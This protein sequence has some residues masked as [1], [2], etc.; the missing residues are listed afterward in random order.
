M[1]V[2]YTGHG[3]GDKYGRPC[4]TVGNWD[5]QKVNHRSGLAT[6]MVKFDVIVQPTLSETRYG[7]FAVQ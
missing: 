2:I 6:C 4:L 1:A 3:A 5:P 7:P